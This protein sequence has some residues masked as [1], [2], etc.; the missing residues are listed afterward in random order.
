MHEGGATGDDA[1][2]AEPAATAAA[3][4]APA[5]SAEPAAAAAPQPDMTE[6]PTGR[7]LSTA[8]RLV[9]HAWA[10]ALAER[11][12]THAG[13]IVLHLILEAPLS[14]KELAVRA[15]V[16]VQTMSR[17][18]DRLER[19][20]HVERRADAGDRRRHLISITDEGRQVWADA[21]SLEADVFPVVSDN[22]ALRR[23]LLDIITLSSER[24]WGGDA[25]DVADATDVA[26]ANDATADEGGAD[27]IGS[28]AGTEGVGADAQPGAEHPAA[29]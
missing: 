27:G 20:G 29:R 1:R 24:R 4:A 10:A 7:L 14:Q 28:T 6:W 15:R 18:I 9:E 21:R 5:A 22:D 12:L 2:L 13:L 11:D 3:P 23:T 16:E 25:V 26:D 17:T 8:S 19:A